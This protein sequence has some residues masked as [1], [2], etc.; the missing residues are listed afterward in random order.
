MEIWVVAVGLLLAVQA[1]LNRKSIMSQIDDLRAAVAA[2]RTEMEED[3]QAILAEIA[4]LGLPDE[5]VSD[6]IAAVGEFGTAL[7]DVPGVTPAPPVEPPVEP[8]P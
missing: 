8:T 7:D 6:L 4:R 1:H 5:D 2:A 3:K